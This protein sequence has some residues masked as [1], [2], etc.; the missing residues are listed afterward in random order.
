[1][2]A[3]IARRLIL[4]L[5]TLLGIM[6][7]NFVV[8]HA[9]PLPRC[10]CHSPQPDQQGGPGHAGTKATLKMEAK[11]ELPGTN[12]HIMACRRMIEYLAHS[13]D[14]C[15]EI[16]CDRKVHQREDDA[17]NDHGSSQK[18]KRIDATSLVRHKG[19]DRVQ[20]KQDDCLEVR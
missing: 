8:I 7:L 11:V 5:P 2:L 19:C 13:L 14:N 12:A 9:A 20:R 3:Y 6:L 1:M 18:A 4:L 10:G 16:R 15:A 17:R